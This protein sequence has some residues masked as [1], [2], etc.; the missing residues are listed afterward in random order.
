M[1]STS[2]L[3]LLQPLSVHLR[4]NIPRIHVAIHALGETGLATEQEKVSRRNKSNKQKN[5]G[6]YSLR[7]IKLLPR[8]WHTLLEALVIHILRNSKGGP[9]GNQD[10]IQM[11]PKRTMNRW[12]ALSRSATPEY[13]PWRTRSSPAPSIP[14]WWPH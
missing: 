5:S 9:G 3:F 11:N 8:V 13:W 14:P 2:E 12:K 10:V 6:S 7:A 4:H 1:V